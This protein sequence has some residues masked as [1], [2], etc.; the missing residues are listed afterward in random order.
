M[1]TSYIAAAVKAKVTLTETHKMG[2]DCLNCGCVPSKALIQSSRLANQMSHG[3]HYG[4][5]AVALEFSFRKVMARVHE[6]ISTVAA[7]DS[8]ARYT[9]LGVQVLQGHARIV[10]P[11]TVEV[12]LTDGGTQRLSTR[13][14]AI[15]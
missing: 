14:N 2:G 4:L 8:V 10:D 15:L 9:E 1:V 12:K 5:S 7:H 3:D 13:S 6:V 11:W